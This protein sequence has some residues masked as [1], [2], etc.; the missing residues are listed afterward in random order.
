MKQSRGRGPASCPDPR[1]NEISMLMYIELKSGYSDNGPAWIG[2][3][4]MS[5]AGRTVYFNG[6]AFKRSGRGSSGNHFDLETGD[7]YWISRVKH[8]GSD[9]HWAGSGK[10][11]IEADSV[12]EYLRRVG[13][14]ELDRSRFVV[15]DKILPADPSKFYELENQKNEAD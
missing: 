3:V 2:R 11:T 7:M 9:R 10:I 12:K 8:D 1:Q 14:R 5:R 6:Q 13:A 4:R 15:S